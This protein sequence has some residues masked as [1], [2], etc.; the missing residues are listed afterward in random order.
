VNTIVQPRF[1]VMDGTIGLEGNGPKSGRPKEMNLVLA[2][3]NLV[4]IDATAAR[5]MGFDPARIEHLT[6]CADHGLGAIAGFAVLGEAIDAVAEPFIPARHN[7]VSGLEMVLRQ[8]LLER[9]IFRTPVLR[10]PSWGARRYY[11]L[12]VWRELFARSGYARQW[13]E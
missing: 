8:P 12:W 10:I 6:L 1:A 5:I 7:A 4:G 13:E 11:D 3:G 2:S 9:L